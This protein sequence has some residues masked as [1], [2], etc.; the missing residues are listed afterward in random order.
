MYSPA[1]AG[2]HSRGLMMIAALESF[3]AVVCHRCAKPIRVSQKLEIRAVQRAS[4]G[5]DLESQVFVLRCR[6]C[7]RESVYSVNQI[8][9]SQ[10]RKLIVSARLPKRNARIAGPVSPPEAR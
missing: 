1:P 6:L 10:S 8:G 3:R 9:I 7:E 4:E 2:L 5:K